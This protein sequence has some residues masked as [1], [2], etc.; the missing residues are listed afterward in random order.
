MTDLFAFTNERTDVVRKRTNSERRRS[1][2]EAVAKYHA[3]LAASSATGLRLG[4]CFNCML[5]ACTGCSH[6]AAAPCAVDPGHKRGYRFLAD[7]GTPAGDG[8]VCA[9]CFWRGHRE[10]AS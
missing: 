3:G 1:T 2:S 7:E 8:T 9:R 4:T 6:D 5:S 10:A